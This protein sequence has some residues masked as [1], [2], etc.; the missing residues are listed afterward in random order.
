MLCAVNEG[1]AIKMFQ[2]RF[3]LKFELF[4]QFMK[5]NFS[6]HIVF[7]EVFPVFNQAYP[8]AEITN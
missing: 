1:D 8:A 2:E 3:Y 6:Q 4:F 5:F 7:E